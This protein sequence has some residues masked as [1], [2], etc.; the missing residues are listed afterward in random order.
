M[1]LVP[2]NKIKN[3]QNL[4]EVEKKDL[5]CLRELLPE[6]HI[7]VVMKKKTSCSLKEKPYSTDVARMYMY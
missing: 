5:N 7:F 4:Y 3:I 6:I 2:I 1:M